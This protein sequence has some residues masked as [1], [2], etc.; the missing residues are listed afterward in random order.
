MTHLSRV[1]AFSPSLRRVSEMVETWELQRFRT[2]PMGISLVIGKDSVNCARW[3]IRHCPSF[4]VLCPVINF[5]WHPLVFFFGGEGASWNFL[6]YSVY[7]VP[8]CSFAVRSPGS[9]SA[10]L[11]LSCFTDSWFPNLYSQSSAIPSCKHILIIEW[12]TEALRTSA[13]L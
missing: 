5:L 4:C 13:W 9:L 7:G 6:G 8:C 1:F 2:G 11:S 3:R 10:A 12:F